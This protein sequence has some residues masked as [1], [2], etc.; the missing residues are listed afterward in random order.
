MEPANDSTQVAAEARPPEHVTLLQR[1][2]AELENRHPIIT[3]V[4]IVIFG[5]ALMHFT[6]AFSFAFCLLRLAYHCVYYALAAFPTAHG[7]ARLGAPNDILNAIHMRLVVEGV[8]RILKF[9]EGDEAE[10]DWL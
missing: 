8:I 2:I 6:F 9:I 1:F 4:S 5:V 7:D 10:V 3:L